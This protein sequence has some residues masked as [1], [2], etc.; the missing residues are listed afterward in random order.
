M[1][2]YLII[3]N[4]FLFRKIGLSSNHHFYKQI[5]ILESM[6]NNFLKQRITPSVLCGVPLVQTFTF[7]LCIKFHE[8]FPPLVFL[9]LSSGTILYENGLSVCPSVCLSVCPSESAITFDPFDL[10]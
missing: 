6:L 3:E 10:R 5:Q 8:V 4:F 1:K 7:Y 9:L 2:K